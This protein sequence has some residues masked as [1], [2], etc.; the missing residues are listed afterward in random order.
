MSRVHEA[1][2]RAAKALPSET[3]L[4]AER[5]VLTAEESTTPPRLAVHAVSCSKELIFRPFARDLLARNRGSHHFDGLAQDEIFKLI[6]QVF[7]IPNTSAPRTVVFSSVDKGSDAS[8]IC[9]RAGEVLASQMSGSVCVVDANL[10]APFLHDLLGVGKSPGFA[11]A[12]V[13]SQPIKDFA[14]PI[15]GGNLWL[16]PSGSPGFETASQFASDRFRARVEEM[17]DQFDCVLITAPQVSSSA[18]AVLLGRMSD[19]VILVVEAHSTRREA[20][21][22]AKETLERANIKLLGAILN[23]RTFPIPKAVYRKL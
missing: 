9:F 1:L 21:L 10:S 7:I 17:E 13:D 23:N 18:E 20:A 6:Q 16:I 19:G 2:Q 12:I 11:D 15:P 22:L 8:V 5:Q 4:N 14:V 3:G